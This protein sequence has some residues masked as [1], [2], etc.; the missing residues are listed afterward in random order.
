MI[1]TTCTP[2]IRL[3]RRQVMHA[4]GYPRGKQPAPRVAARFDALWDDARRLARPKGSHLEV[5]AAEAERLGVDRRGDRVVLAVCTVGDALERRSQE[6]TDRG[7]LLD[8][9]LFDAVGSAAAEAT[10]SA[11]NR[12]LCAEAHEHHRHLSARFSPGYRGWDIQFQRPLLRLLRS[13]QIGVS[14]S[15]GMMMMPRKSVSF[16][17]RLKPGPAP[18]DES[19][20][21]DRCRRC[22]LKTCAY[23]RV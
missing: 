23:R 2:E 18:V 3:T 17:A 19:G 9:L 16:A 11:L 22:D 6:A 5:D 21:V 1:P 8:A 20:G 14:L 7:N 4:L 13:E 12:V 15:D 10:A